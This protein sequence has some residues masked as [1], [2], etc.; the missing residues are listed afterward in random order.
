MIAVIDDVNPPQPLYPEISTIL[1]TGAEAGGSYCHVRTHANANGTNSSGPLSALA[2]ET[3][4]LASTTI[5]YV[6][7][8]G[9]R[10]GPSGGGVW[11]AQKHAKRD[12][13]TVRLES[14]ASELKAVCSRNVDKRAALKQIGDTEQGRLT[15]MS[16]HVALAKT[17]GP[18]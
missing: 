15:V 7:F 9:T 18:Q 12:L 4:P 16:V 13:D 3:F 11:K 14:A 8:P 17:G 1:A 10:A 6:T 2:S 5:L